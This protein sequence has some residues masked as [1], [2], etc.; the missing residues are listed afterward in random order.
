MILKE[1]MPYEE[2]KNCTIMKEIHYILAG[3]VKVISYS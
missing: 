2:N 1:I 3:L